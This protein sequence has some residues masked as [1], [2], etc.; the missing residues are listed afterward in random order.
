[1]DKRA[2]AAITRATLDGMP[3]RPREHELEAESQTAFEEAL[4]SSFVVRR[5]SP[6]Y[7][8]DCDVEEFDGGHATGVH[9]NA[10]LKATDEPDLAKALA[11]PLA[12]A[13]VTYYRSLALPV[14]M[15]RYLAS[16][17]SLYARWFHTHPD[18]HSAPD[19]RTV[20]F[21]WRPE[22]GW[23]DATA[24]DLA[25]Q[26]RAF[27]DLRQAALALPLSVNIEAGAALPGDVS[28]PEIEIALQAAARQSQG[29]VRLA[30]IGTGTVLVE[31]DRL[32]A[33]LSAVSGASV[34]LDEGYE[35]GDA[36]G[37]L[38][39]DLMVLL[40]LALW[41]AGQADVC[42]RLAGTFL[43][44]ALAALEPPFVLGAASAMGDARRMR[45]AARTFDALDA[46][47][48]D[49]A[50]SAASVLSSLAINYGDRLD[51]DE[52]AAFRTAFD[53][54]IA[55]RLEA[56]SPVSAGRVTYNLGAFLRSIREP[57]EAVDQYDGALKLDPGYRDRLYYWTELAGVLFISREYARAVDAYDQ[58]LDL[59]AND[60][61]RALRADAV[62]YSGRYAEARE[63]LRDY[64]VEKGDI[65]EAGAEWG[66][67]GIVLDRIVDELGIP[68]QARDADAAR[69]L[70]GQLAHL[71]PEN[72]DAG[73]ELCTR[74]LKRDALSPLPWFNL[75]RC[76][77]DRGRR[78]E[79][80]EAYLAAALI[81]EGDPE[82]WVNAF[83]LH[84][85]EGATSVLG[86]ILVTADRMTAGKL[87]GRL[88][89]FARE[90]G[91][92]FP[93]EDFL[94]AVNGLLKDLP[95]EISDE[96]GPLRLR[97]IDPDT[98]EVLTRE[99]RP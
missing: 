68:E 9:Y 15:V 70:A 19:Q 37:T 35:P 49:R 4:G 43:P 48:D 47:G 46:R 44:E 6:D 69:D 7:G 31:S 29:L 61:T 53:D 8:I 28:R 81:Y 87:M 30:E 84:W 99:F 11:Y 77:L 72:P 82:S 26:A 21:R 41:R 63:L 17:G 66:L 45:E 85:Q 39:A 65:F 23:T 36:A 62:M 58:A 98:G 5:R 3:Q 79:A 25:R 57:I 42:A 1:M 56:G 55:R 10:Q 52:R 75:A 24:A 71:P 32:G 92:D 50:T 80:A 12:V 20:T 34:A 54:A 59:G 13:H 74:A 22:D 96:R 95:S 16:T 89:A 73:A 51:K 64:L 76:D 90:Q 60:F 67:K 94:N 38:A 88:A 78:A 18:L 40:A 93:R 83:A 27:V 2:I 97:F 14:L 33:Y 86:P 91:D